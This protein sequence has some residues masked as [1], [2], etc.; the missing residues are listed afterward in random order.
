VGFFGIEPDYGL[1][2]FDIALLNLFKIILAPSQVL[3]QH[4]L[5]EAFRITFALR[6]VGVVM[7]MNKRSVAP[8]SAF[9]I[10]AELALELTAVT[11]LDAL[12]LERC[13]AKLL[14]KVLGVQTVELRVGVGEREPTL[15][16]G[17]GY[18]VALQPIAETGHRVYRHKI[19]RLL[20]LVST[21]PLLLT[22]LLDSQNKIPTCSMQA[23]SLLQI[24]HQTPTL[25]LPKQSP[26][27]IL[28][29]RRYPILRTIPVQYRLDRLIA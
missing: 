18:Y 3:L 11:C 13:V 12:D 19:L 28:R 9:D 4:C 1:P 10:T 14:E 7:K 22:P 29:Y 6:T 24:F 25:H 20:L 15:Q 21:T 23:H 27:R 5:V 16:I 2:K 17:S 26:N 8:F